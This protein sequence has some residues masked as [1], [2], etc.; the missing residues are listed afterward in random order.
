MK[1]TFA[2]PSR[3]YLE[4]ENQ[5]GNTVL[6]DAYKSP[7]FMVMHTFQDRDFAKAMIMS[8]SP[9]ILE[10][11]RQEEEFYAKKDSKVMISSQSYEKVYRMPDGGYASRDL[12]IR[13]DRGSDFVF[14]L[15]PMILYQDSDFRESLSIDLE[16]DARLIFSNCFVAGRVGRGESFAFKSYRTSLDIN[17]D[18]NLIYTERNLL[19][20]QEQN[21]TG[22][23]MMEGY[24]H[25]LSMV[26][27]NF[28]QDEKIAVLREIIERHSQKRGLRGGASHTFRGDLQIRIL[29][30]MGQD[31]IECEREII[32]YLIEKGGR[33][34][35]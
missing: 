4:F 31:L 23:G 24:D 33:R 19:R 14:K 29:G 15:L 12:K 18:G 20:P 25:F 16:G 30:K 9:G 35:I 13:G 7:P 22:L 32:D 26:V 3:L 21:L 5:K 34:C 17:L 1:K 2:R 28:A 6:R 10:G 11:D 8:S 27:V